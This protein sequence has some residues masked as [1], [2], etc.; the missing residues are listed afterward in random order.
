MPPKRKAAPSAASGGS[1][2]S[3]KVSRTRQPA[4][5][6]KLAAQLDMYI[7]RSD[8]ED[9][10]EPDAAT[11]STSQRIVAAQGQQ[12]E[13]ESDEAS[14]VSSDDDGASEAADSDGDVEGAKMRTVSAANL[15][16]L[17]GL[18]KNKAIDVSQKDAKQK[19]KDL[20]RSDR[21]E[22]EE[23]RKRIVAERKARLAQPPSDDEEDE[24]SDEDMSDDDEEPAK[25]GEKKNYQEYSDVSEGEEVGASSDDDEPVQRQKPL[26]KVNDE[27]AEAAYLARLGKRKA[28]EQH[29]HEVERQKRINAKLPVRKLDGDDSADSSD[30]DV[31]LDDAI[32]SD[33]SDEME[34]DY[35]QESEPSDLGSSDDDDSA[36]Q[37]SRAIHAPL[38]RSAQ[39]DS[40]SDSASHPAAPTPAAPLSSI[41]HSSRFNLTAP[42]EILLTSHPCRLP[43]A[44]PSS[45]KRKAALAHKAQLATAANQTLLLA[46]N[47]IAS[48]SS[49]IVADPENSLG[50]LKRLAVFAGATV[51]APPEKIPEIR[52]EQ[53]AAKAR[54]GRAAVEARPV[55]VGVPPAVRQLA[56]LSMLAVFVDVLPG[57]RIRSLTEKEQEEKVGQDVARRREFEAGL[58]GVYRDFLEL[59]EAE[60]KAASVA[61]N[62][63]EKAAVKVFTT[64]AVRAVHFNF[65]T[66]ILGVVVARMS[67]RRWGPD[68][69]ACYDAIRTVVL[70]DLTGE[71]SLEV[72]RL[73]HRMTKE[74]RYKVNSHVLDV[75]LH[76]RLR[77]ELG[78]K[79]SSTTTSTDPDADAARAAREHAERRAAIKAREKRGKAGGK[80]SSKDVR[81][82]MATH[83][84]KKQVKK[85]KQ[86]REI[87]HEM[88]EAEATVDLEERERHQTE[89]LKLVF[90][91][92]FTVLKREVGSVGLGVLE[93]TMKGLSMYAHR[94]NVDFF[95]DLL[96][97]LKHHISTN[98][99]LL[100]DPTSAAHADTDDSGGSDTDG[101]DNIL[102]DQTTLTTTI[103]HMIVALKT[104]FDL[105]LGQAEGSV[106]NLDLTDV[107][108]H[109]YYVLFFLPFVSESHLTFTASASTV[110]DLALDALYAILVR[111]RTRFAPH[112]LAAFAKRLAVVGLHL[113]LTASSGP[114]KVL[115]ILAHLL[116]HQSTSSAV[117]QLALLDLEDR[118]R[119]G[120]YASE[121]GNLNTT[122]VL[123]SGQT[124]LWELCLLKRSGNAEVADEADRV[125][126][127]KDEAL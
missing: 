74:R 66:N 106:L 103:R 31:D 95:R 48:L 4:R 32:D 93:S 11:P 14:H 12:Y 81:K 92:Y 53:A 90:V 43:R 62:K 75:L 126:A 57:Y 39:P 118:S 100:H 127:L 33:N 42:Y 6:P 64:L 60:L 87:E 121:G 34:G 98:A 86:L 105:F 125:W 122:G 52:A 104:T 108:G 94:V 89:T 21:R 37:P 77:D 27:D 120:T 28:R 46:R 26:K 40:D 45:A 13:P 65:R 35:R 5:R 76:L 2:S 9:E 123:E 110:V 25:K 7:R 1:S 15:A 61:P 54:G 96:S 84:S 79:R 112:V 102:L 44:P 47:Q 20:K 116:T 55:K 38:P 10:S 119:N 51:S 17:S 69:T 29:E 36:A 107:L 82:G 22:F 24:F 18:D 78:N 114:K 97:V 115:R 23:T 30:E 88:K 113:P 50:L 16:F 83:L 49:Q 56:M 73:I 70:S 91:L 68:E 111:S 63:L 59:C 124:V 67:R 58:V 117:G 72:V 71:I 109:F 99:S 80:F 101:A 41:T 8:D 85:Q 3:S 19:A